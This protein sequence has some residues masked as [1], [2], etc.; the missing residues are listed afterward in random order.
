[1]LQIDKSAKGRMRD[2]VSGYSNWSLVKP[3]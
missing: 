2:I 3:K 1:L